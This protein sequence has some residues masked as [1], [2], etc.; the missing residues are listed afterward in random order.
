MHSKKEARLKRL[1]RGIYKR[2]RDNHRL[3]YAAIDALFRQ[4]FLYT[5]TKL[6]SCYY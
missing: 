3:A 6:Y 4:C 5:I 2:Y 1:T